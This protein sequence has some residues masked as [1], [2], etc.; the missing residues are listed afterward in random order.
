MAIFEL[1]AA[2]LGSHGTPPFVNIFHVLCTSDN[3]DTVAA[4]LP[5]I[6]QDFYDAWAGYMQPGTSWVLFD[7]ILDLETTPPTIYT[8]AQKTSAP[9]GSTT[10]LPSQLSAVLSWR[11]PQ[12]GPAYRGRTYLGPLNTSANADGGI[13]SAM[14]SAIK[15][16]GDQLIADV[17]GIV[18]LNPASLVVYSRAHNR[19]TD[20]VGCDTQVRFRTQRRRN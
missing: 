7:R 2:S 15:S 10:A 18:S 8:E 19:A 9:S 12:A 17:A 11:T 14:N 16:A 3:N 4:A 13:A 6:F 20:I 5:S 1:R